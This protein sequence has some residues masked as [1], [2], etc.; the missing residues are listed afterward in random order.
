LYFFTFLKIESVD[1]II[2]TLSQPNDP[3]QLQNVAKE[4]LN[5]QKLVDKSL[6]P[7]YFIF[8]L[9]TKLKNELLEF[10]KISQQKE[11]SI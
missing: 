8:L 6:E 3:F 1:I 4:L 5:V 11:T 9:I 7:A 10:K 2:E